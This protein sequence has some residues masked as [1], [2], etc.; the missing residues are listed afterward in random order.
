MEFSKIQKEEQLIEY[1]DDINQR[2]KERKFIYHYTTINRFFDI[3]ESK[4]W[5]L[6][7]PKCMNDQ[8]EYKNN[9]AKKAR[10]LFFASFMADSVESIGM[11]SMYSQPWEN[12]VQLAI[13]VNVAKKWVKSITNIRVISCENNKPIGKVIRCDSKNKVFLSAVAYSNCDNHEG[14]REKITWSTATNYSILN[15]SHRSDLTG[16][17]KDSAWDYEKEIR[18][19]AIIDN[20]NDYSR[21]AIDIPEEVFDSIELVAS[22]LF[23][24]DIK[25]RIEAKIEKTI[26]TKNSIFKDKFLTTS[27]CNECMMKS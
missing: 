7:N 5:F 27:A 3:Y 25:E 2:L 6:S 16:Y 17:I 1:L 18:I 13:P 23:N 20:D 4:L 24:G 22:P 14:E 19:K 11:W 8:L 21:L 12:G 26:I 15:A 10:N 9:D